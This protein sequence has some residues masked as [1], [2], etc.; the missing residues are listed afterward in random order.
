MKIG[1]FIFTFTFIYILAL[2]IGFIYG[3]TSSGNGTKET[4]ILSGI[5]LAVI[6]LLLI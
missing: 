6:T 2:Y 3:K 5:M 4:F 1:F